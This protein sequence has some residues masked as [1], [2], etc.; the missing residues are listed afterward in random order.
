[1]VAMVPWPNLI[2]GAVGVAG[3][4]GTILAAWMT[5]KR[6]TANLMLSISADYGRNRLGDKRRIYA[7]YQASLDSLILA[8]SRLDVLRRRR[9]MADDDLAALRAGLTE[10]LSALGELR[11]IAPEELGQ[12][13][14]EMASA[15]ADYAQHNSQPG[16]PSKLPEIRERLYVAMRA[17]L[18]EPV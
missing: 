2:T 4:G 18:G 17:D 16:D 5:G 9:S 10:M 15:T 14:Q 12:L 1:M 6:Q 3:I 7:R 8:I 11:L 13:A